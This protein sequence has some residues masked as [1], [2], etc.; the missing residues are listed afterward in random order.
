[1]ITNVSMS[2]LATN[3]ILRFELDILAIYVG[4]RIAAVNVTHPGRPHIVFFGSS[5]KNT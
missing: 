5:A 2:R 4:L 3:G 1:M